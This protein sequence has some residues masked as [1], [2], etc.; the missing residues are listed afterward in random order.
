MAP[1]LPIRF[2]AGVEGTRFGK[3]CFDADWLLK[4]V[5]VNLEDLGVKDFETWYDLVERDFQFSTSPISPKILTRF[6]FMPTVNRVNVVDDVVLLEKFRMGVF[7]EIMY[8]EVNG[9]PVADLDSFLYEPSE[10][11][12]KSFSNIYSVAA[13]KNETL[14][15]L[16]GIT[17]LASLAKGLLQEED[18][19]DIRYWLK[20]YSVERIETPPD[21]QMLYV[22]NQKSGFSISGGVNLM[23][24]AT[25]LKGGDAGALKELVITTRP[26]VDAVTW[27]FEILMNDGQVTG[28]NMPANLSDPYRIASL[29]Q[30]AWFL[31]HK[32]RYK[33]ALEA[34]DSAFEKAPEFVAEEYWMKAVILREYGLATSATPGMSQ[35]LAEYRLELAISMF[36]KSVALN[37]EFA[38]AHFELGVTLGALGDHKASIQCLERAITIDKDYS[39]AYF[40]LGVEHNH[41]G[42]RARGAE[43]LKLF[44]SKEPS[45]L[46]AGEARII[47][48]HFN[49]EATHFANKKNFIDANLGISFTYTA[50]WVVL[51]RDD[52][53]KKSKGMIGAGNPNLVLAV[54]NLDDWDQNVTIQLINMRQQ[55]ILSK[56]QLYELATTLDRSMPQQYTNFKKVSHKVITIQGSPTLNTL[57]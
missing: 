36:K 31:Y 7:T 6:W 55:G 18:P 56:Q 1:I 2:F 22:E 19:V 29:C 43:Y 40:K 28:V 54:G 20:E 34:L 12:S 52:I 13:K 45:G 25:R 50:D 11:F 16:L 9:T 44:L 42:D 21:V 15:L 53:A 41:A 35:A 48:N 10:G 27:T 39:P 51:R 37:P 4:R 47:L 32:K 14:N 5:S 30:H 3:V 26:S 33:D 46:H 8:A 17:R 24:L 57:C 49:K 23:T 38:P